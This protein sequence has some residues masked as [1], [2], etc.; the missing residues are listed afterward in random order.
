[1]Y[2]KFQEKEASKGLIGKEWGGKFG[3]FGQ[4][5]NP[6]RK[7]WIENVKKNLLE[8]VRFDLTTLGLQ[9]QSST[10]ELWVQLITRCIYLNNTKLSSS[11]AILAPKRGMKIQR[12]MISLNSLAQIGVFVHIQCPYI[13]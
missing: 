5:L 11:L 10:N 2:F 12:F 8:R 1:M 6:G 13:M 9:K 3:G 7:I 4:D